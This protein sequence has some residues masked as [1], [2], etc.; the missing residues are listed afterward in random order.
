MVSFTTIL[1]LASMAVFSAN[2]FDR[3][4]RYPYDNCG[5][6]LASYGLYPP[7]SVVPL[8]GYTYEELQAA[9]NTTDGSRI[10]DAL[11]SCDSEAGAISYIQWCGGGGKCGTGVVPN[12]NCTP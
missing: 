5:W 12:D 6:V 9:A 10:Y 11:Y 2:A 4:C 1:T 8:K 3:P 7:F